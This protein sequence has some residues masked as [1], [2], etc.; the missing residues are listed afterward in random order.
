MELG[1]QGIADLCRMS[2]KDLA[3]FL[4]SLSLEAN[5]ALIADRILLEIRER[6]HFLCEVGLGYL[7]LDRRS[8]TL[9]GGEGQRVRLATQI[10]SSLMGVLYILDEPSIGLHARDHGRLL[11]S[12]IRLRDMGNS[13]L[14]VEHDE[15]TMRS[16][17]HIIDMGPGA[18]AHGGRV[19]AQGSPTELQR[20]EASLTGAYLSGRRRI[21]VPRTRRQAKGRELVLVGCRENNLK[22]VTLRL[23]LGVMSVV[24]GVSAP[25]PS[26]PAPPNPK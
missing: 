4:G 23:P 8:A 19:V 9:S 22:N 6:L 11:K 1:G 2:C 7:S 15:A 16:A 14:V 21:P 3:D 17:D 25:R 12:L 5:E 24:T 10:G 13:V 26:A 18:G 20:S